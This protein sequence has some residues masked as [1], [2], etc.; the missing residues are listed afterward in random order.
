MDINILE[1][2]IKSCI[3]N[4]FISNNDDNNCWRLIDLVS[5]QCTCRMKLS[6]GYSSVHD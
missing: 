2:V 6:A 4:L 1:I 5:M 3:H